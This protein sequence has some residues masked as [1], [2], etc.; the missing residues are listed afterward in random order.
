M[1]RKLELLH[2]KSLVVFGHWKAFIL[3][4]EMVST[5]LIVEHLILFCGN[6]DF[7]TEL[8]LALMGNHL[9]RLLGSVGIG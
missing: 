6:L 5:F 2:N 9:T 1:F 4:C 7:E 8:K 3:N